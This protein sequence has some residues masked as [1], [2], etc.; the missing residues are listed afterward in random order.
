LNGKALESKVVRPVLVK[1][2]AVDRVAEDR[3]VIHAISSAGALG[4]WVGGVCRQ[5]K[6]Q[7]RET[8]HPFSNFAHGETVR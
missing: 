1:V 3:A 2:A 5:N 6:N 7:S 8:H 4:N